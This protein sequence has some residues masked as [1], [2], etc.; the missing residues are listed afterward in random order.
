MATESR[1]TP[2]GLVIDANVLIALCA[3]ESDKYA[4]ADSELNRYAKQGYEFFAPGVI[5]AESLYV[6]CKKLQENTLSPLEHADA[7]MDLS[8]YMSMIDPPPN[9]DRSLITRAE[10]IRKAYGCSHSAD[11]LYIAL[12]EDLL[13]RGVAELLTFDSQIQN[14]IKNNAASVKVNVLVPSFPPPA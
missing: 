12:V 10:E 5:I 7:I 3:K 8:T 14:Q 13:S 6:L 2:P 11:G 1:T 9:G 4:I